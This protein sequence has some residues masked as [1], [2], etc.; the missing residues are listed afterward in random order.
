MNVSEDVR[1][2]INSRTEPEH[3]DSTSDF[4]ALNLNMDMKTLKLKSDYEVVKVK[5][6]A[7]KRSIILS[8]EL[9]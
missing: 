8:G 4:G 6:E 5:F 1:K 7:E 9:C 2:D 3:Q